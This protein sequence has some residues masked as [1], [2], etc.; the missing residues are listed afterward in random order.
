MF[1]YFIL[2]KVS[3]VNITNIKKE[4]IMINLKNV[5]CFIIFVILFIISGVSAHAWT[6]NNTN[7][8]WCNLQYPPT[9][10]IDGFPINIFGQIFINGLTNNYS[11]PAPGIIAEIGYGPY[12]TDPTVNQKW[13][14]RQAVPNPDYNFL[15]NNDEYVGTLDIPYTGIFSYT[16]RYSRDAGAT[17]TLADLDGTQNGIDYLSQFGTATVLT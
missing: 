2:R 5:I 1:I 17:W 7:A 14:W 6:W 13:V 10:I 16:Y 15:S 8:D 11:T 3:C 9:A 4:V 12:L